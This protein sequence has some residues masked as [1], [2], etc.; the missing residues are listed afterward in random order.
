L[1]RERFAMVA[2]RQLGE[3]G[4]LKD[5][6]PMLGN[7]AFKHL[8]TSV[9]YAA[10]AA[11]TLAGAVRRSSLV[12]ALK[13]VCNLLTNHPA[14]STPRSGPDDCSAAASPARLL[15]MERIRASARRR[16]R[17]SSIIMCCVGPD[18]FRHLTKY[19]W[20]AS[21]NSVANNCPT[22]WLSRRNAGKAMNWLK[23][24]KR[25]VP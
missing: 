25:Y 13:N 14:S 20:L 5:T 17:P 22:R 12:A 24:R 4:L 9:E 2:C 1:P 7:I 10:R 8:V 23:R 15:L 3:H 21:T 19:V 18:I 16:F 11:H 6:L